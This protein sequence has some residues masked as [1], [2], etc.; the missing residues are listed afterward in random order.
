[1]F[2]R[3]TPQ[4][5]SKKSTYKHDSVNMLKTRLKEINLKRSQR[6]DTFLLKTTKRLPFQEATK[7]IPVNKTHGKE[8]KDDASDEIRN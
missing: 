6:K 4:K 3:H 1:M 2:K 7:K 5:V 8:K